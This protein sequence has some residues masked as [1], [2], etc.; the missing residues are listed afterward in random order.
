MGA[1]SSKLRALEGDRIAFFCPGCNEAHQISVRPG[2][3]WQYDGNAEQP[4]FSPSVLVSGL[5]RGKLPDGTWDGTWVLDEN[6][7]PVTALCHSFVKAGQ[8]QFLQDCTHALAG[9][10]VALPD[11][12]TKA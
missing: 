12:P 1:L 9:Q 2:T 6:N 3:G 5:L 10:T 11:W 4:T 8:I 7:N